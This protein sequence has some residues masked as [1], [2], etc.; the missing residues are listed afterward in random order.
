MKAMLLLLSALI[1]LYVLP[2]IDFR[3]T[4]DLEDLTI[5][6][7]EYEQMKTEREPWGEPVSFQL[8]FNDI[9]LPYD[10]QTDL[11]LYSINEGEGIPENPSIQ[12]QSDD[13]N[14]YELV[15]EE[16]ALEN[17][18]IQN[19]ETIKFM[20][21]DD[22]YY[23]EFQ[24][25]LTTLPVITIN[26]DQ[27]RSD[28]QYPILA[29]DT[30]A[31]FQLFD[32]R[33]DIPKEERLV[34]SRTKVRLRGAT[35]LAYPQ[36]QMRLNLRDISIGGAEKNNHLDLLG[37]RED[38]DWILY[39]PYSDP[40]KIRNTFSTNLWYNT[41]AHNNDKGIANGTEGKFVEVFIDN[42]YWG[43]YTLMYPIDTKQLEL[44]FSE[45]SPLESD[46]YYRKNGNIPLD[47]QAFLNSGNV[48]TA[49]GVEIRFPDEPINDSSQWSPFMEHA[50]MITASEDKKDEVRKYLSSRLDLNNQIDY[51]LFY[52][53]AQAHDN[54]TKNRNYIAYWEEESHHMLESPWDLD[55][56]WG[57]KWQSHLP[58][59]VSVVG[60]SDEN[61]LLFPSAVT[62]AL[63]FGMSDVTD[64]LMNR[65]SEL[66]QTM[67]SEENL[68]GVLNEYENQ[69]YGS[70]AAERDKNRWPE[71][72]HAAD[73][74]ALKQYVQERLVH[75]DRF[76]YEEIGGEVEHAGE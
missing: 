25:A 13:T 41:S 26:L 2:Q 60:T 39:A 49:S 51:F 59:N 75:M 64:Q 69:I 14:T 58:L 23:K 11:F 15:F 76:I 30:V 29:H 74:S 36:K 27:P 71:S 42:K 63:E 54:D 20:A 68:I 66:R 46:F 9:S 44:S 37:M 28:D 72:N 7:A 73:A 21:Y 3:Q 33:E 1:G 48:L 35:S 43:I 70:G 40:E 61:P 55:L 5:S 22:E 47:N 16:K 65:Y 18:D 45:E 6:S 50:D 56:T 10:K 24:L 38:D 4:V 12:P 34:V 52:T 19:S 31:Q 8:L 67:W 62:K 17:L 32:N 57:N 53:L